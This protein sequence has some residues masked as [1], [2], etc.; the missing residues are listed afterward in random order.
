M[1]E[2]AL[3]PPEQAEIV[4][5]GLPLEVTQVWRSGVKNFPRVFRECINHMEGEEVFDKHKTCDLGDIKAKNYSEFETK[6]NEAMEEFNEKA[7]YVF[8]GGEH[9]ASLP[10]IKHYYHKFKPTILRLDAHA[11][12][13]DEYE[14]KKHS[15][16]S[17]YSRILEFIPKNKIIQVGLRS[18]SEECREKSKDIKSFRNT[19]GVLKEV[20]SPVLIDLDFD[21]LSL[22]DAPGVSVP[23]PYGLSLNSVTDLLINI[24]KKH[25]TLG[26]IITEINESEVGITSVNA[27]GLVM[28]LLK[29]VLRSGD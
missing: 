17:V 23:E 4:F 6:F 24:I 28:K 13:R 21:V 8:L 14:G 26:I 29:E 7:F 16:A 10:V 11:D 3:Y 2:G 12:M 25:K 18:Y 15:R 1:I 22:S 27:A 9:L 19:E 20:K 5:L